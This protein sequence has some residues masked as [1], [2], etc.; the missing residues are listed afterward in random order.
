MCGYLIP[1]NKQLPVKR[2]FIKVIKKIP[3]GGVLRVIFAF[4]KLRS[5][6]RV[7]K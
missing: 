3:K 6:I 7:F 1:A 2:F 5:V 4:A